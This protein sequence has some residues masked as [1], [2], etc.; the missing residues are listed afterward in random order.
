VVAGIVLTAL[1]SLA[2]AASYTNNFSGSGS[3]TAFSAEGVDANWTVSGGVYQFSTNSTAIAA[4]TASVPVP[5]VAGSSF[6]IETQ[7]NVSSLGN[8]NGNGVTLGFGVLGAS[9][10]F[11]GAAGSSYYLAD[12]QVATTGTAGNLRI[13]SQGDPNGFTNAAVNVDDN[14]GSAGLAINLNTTYTLRLVGTYVGTTL[15]MTLGVFDANGIQ[16]GSS[17]TASDTSPLTGENFGYRNRVG[18]GGGTFTAD[19]DNFSIMPVPEPSSVVLLGLGASMAAF[20][21]RRSGARA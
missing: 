19:F 16:I 3:N 17:A 20:V 4:D 10:G 9:T 21:R 5:G 18:L 7:F 13:L 12:W 1:P 15:N 6:T 2:T 11:G 14:A 8:V